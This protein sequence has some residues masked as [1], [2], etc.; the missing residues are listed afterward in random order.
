[1]SY[2]R[3]IHRNY[4]TG[5]YGSTEVP[6]AI[7]LIAGD[8]RRLEKDTQDDAHIPAYARYAGITEDQARKVFELFFNGS[9]LASLMLPVP[10][11][12]NDKA[13]G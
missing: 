3:V 11:D 12:D 2:V 6:G 8:L 7:A 10:G 9:P 5:D 13:E 1:M 4:L